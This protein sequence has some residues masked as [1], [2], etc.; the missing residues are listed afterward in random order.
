MWDQWS[1][2]GKKGLPMGLKRGKVRSTVV[3]WVNWL[4]A[5]ERQYMVGYRWERL[6]TLKIVAQYRE[7]ERVYQWLSDVGQGWVRMVEFG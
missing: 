7:I 1:S 3:R 5:I 4:E 6:V 2:I